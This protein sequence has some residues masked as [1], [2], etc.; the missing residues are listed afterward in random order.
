MS[1]KWVSLVAI[2]VTPFLGAD[3][4]QNE[5]SLMQQEIKHVVLVMLENRSFDNVLAWLYGHKSAPLQFIPATTD[6]HFIGLSEETL[7]QYT[8]VLKDASGNTIYSCA[9]IKGVPSVA[10]GPYINSPSTDPNEPFPNVTTQIF[11]DGSQ[12]TMS[13]FLQ[14]FAGLWDPKTWVKEKINICAV[15]ET[16]TARELPV[17]HGLAKH[18]AVSDLWF[19]SV[20]TQT[21]PNRAFSICG[22]SDGQTVNGPLGRSLFQ[23][24]TIWNRLVEESPE[25]TWTIFWQC[26][27]VPGLIPGPYTGTNNFVSMGRIP[28]L[29]EHYQKMDVFHDL[30]RRGQLPD[31]SY[32]EPQ[33]TLSANLCPKDCLVELFGE[34]QDFI[35]GLQGND[36]HPPGDVRTCEDLL[37]NI[38][39]SLIANPEAWQQTLLIVTFDE[40]GGLFDHVPPPASIAPDS[41][42]QEG[43]KF[44]RYGVRVPAIFIS[45]RVQRRTIIRAEEG[46]F[47]FDHT[48]LIATILKWKG[49][50]PA[51]WKMGSRVDAAP[52][53]ENVVTLS[54]ARRDRVLKPSFAV[55]P[56]ADPSDVVHIGDSFYLRNKDGQY[57]TLSQT[58]FKTDVRVGSSQDKVA[59]SFVGGQGAL[60]HGSFIIIQS[61]DPALG[62]ANIL[63]TSPYHSDCIYAENQHGP[64]QWWTIKSYDRPYVGAVVQYGDRV[65]LENHIYLDPFTFLPARLIQD[66]SV[67]GGFLKAQPIT[68]R[69]S[70]DNYW[71]LEK[72]DAGN[73]QYA[74]QQI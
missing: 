59:L 25:T 16:Y 27:M 74:P 19:S 43:F 67:F 30:A 26:D 57:L 18:Y 63:G 1:L 15:M 44:D 65:Y 40:H 5:A 62:S 20:P 29:N 72:A 38:Y 73:I 36:L 41:C 71:V 4:G 47:P 7:A 50:D 12:P 66:N 49:V 28:N 21:N 3:E 39:T 35:G 9:P 48:S 53:F 14:D 46:G 54:D 2:C 70:E 37:A 22:T 8:N 51:Q 31:F 24:D 68:D 55:L 42:F 58:L 33:C 61:S 69:G 23:S 52:T 6:P 34:D 17:L 10:K 45:P 64:Q 60:T 13:G 56:K 32:I 11:N